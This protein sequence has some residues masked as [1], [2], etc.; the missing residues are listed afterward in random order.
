MTHQKKRLEELSALN[1]THKNV[2]FRQT[3]KLVLVMLRSVI[4]WL[5][6]L[7][8]VTLE[9]IEFGCVHKLYPWIR[10]CVPAVR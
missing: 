4:H 1:K 8:S 5:H 3:I 9:E 2:V 10:A 6:G 7:W